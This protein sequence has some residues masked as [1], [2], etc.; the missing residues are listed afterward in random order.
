MR[1]YKIKVKCGLYI[2]RN[3]RAIETKQVE[4]KK[5]RELD[6]C[7]IRDVLMLLGLTWDILSKCLTRF[8]FL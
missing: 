1:I 4:G 8:D 2:V 6:F 7:N 5:T 3:E